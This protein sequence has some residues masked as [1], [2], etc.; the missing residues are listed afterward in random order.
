M[1]SISF[2]GSKL[3]ENMKN[4]HTFKNKFQL[5]ILKTFTSHIYL[6]KIKCKDG[7]SYFYKNH[8]YG[9]LKKEKKIFR[10]FV[11]K[12]PSFS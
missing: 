9:Q 5:I 2:T 1:F 11:L 7:G 6:P 3:N 10:Y 12:I 4:D 8:Q